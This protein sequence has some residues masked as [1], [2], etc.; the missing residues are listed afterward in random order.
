MSIWGGGMPQSGQNSTGKRTG[1]A[2]IPSDCLPEYSLK[3]KYIITTIYPS[4][5][6][7]LLIEKRSEAISLSNSA[8]IKPQIEDRRTQA[9]SQQNE[10][11]ADKPD[12]H[13]ALSMP[14]QD[15]ALQSAQER[16]SD[17]MSGRP[18]QGGSTGF[19]GKHRLKYRSERGGTGGVRS[20]ELPRGRF[21]G[22]QRNVMLTCLLEDLSES[23]FTGL[24]RITQDQNV[25]VLVLEKGKVILAGHGDFAGQDAWNEILSFANVLVD[26][27]LNE[28]S[29]AQMN[30]ALEFNPEWKIDV[31]SPGDFRSDPTA[32]EE[33]QSE[34]FD[35]SVP[36][37]EE[38]RKLPTNNAS[39]LVESEQGMKNVS[40]TIP[41]VAFEPLERDSALFETKAAGREKRPIQVSDVPEQWRLMSVNRR[42]NLS[43]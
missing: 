3:P 15:A 31:P 32:E 25:M 36:I 29:G 27:Q 38:S 28:L 33:G 35:Q 12:W 2:S 16:R 17:V 20:M 1:S 11:I 23:N 43:V 26:A 13:R 7:S 39:S 5:A 30:L 42:E 22:V 21:R 14:V 4:P 9:L 18:G 24:C 6:E 10:R 8:A 37:G 40:E 34:P 19:P 41:A